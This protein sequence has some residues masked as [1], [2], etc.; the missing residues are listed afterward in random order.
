MQFYDMARKVIEEECEDYFL[1]IADLSHSKQAT[2]EQYASLIA[3]YPRSISIGITLPPETFKK[4]LL[5][6][7]VVYN[8]TNNQLNTITEYLSTLLEQEGYKALAVP[9]ALRTN[10]G[11]F[12]SLHRLAAISADLG[13]IEKNMVVTP[14]V[15][16]GVNWGTVITDAPIGVMNK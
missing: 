13:R 1:G 7:S 8:E 3:I 10:K 14:E 9:K 4:S 12:V 11:I 15:G 16:T 6:N 5:R 2:S